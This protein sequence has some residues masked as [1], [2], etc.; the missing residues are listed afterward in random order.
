MKM[1]RPRES[2][3]P[4]QLFVG[5]YARPKNIRI[6]HRPI[7]IQYVVDS[8]T[9]SDTI[10]N[11]PHEATERSIGGGEQPLQLPAERQGW[12]WRER[13]RHESNY[14]TPN[15]SSTRSWHRALPIAYSLMLLPRSP[16]SILPG[17]LV[18]LWREAYG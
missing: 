16:G 18:E 10:S 13:R 7:L 17:I 6:Q 8:G 14:G 15:V 9:Q 5:Q 1:V 2:Y 11:V 4:G 3:S 12:L